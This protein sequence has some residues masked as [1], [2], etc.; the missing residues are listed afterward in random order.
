M[1]FH[2]ALTQPAKQAT[3]PLYIYFKISMR[4]KESRKLIFK[5][6]L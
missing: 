6:L 3:R 2:H 5:K 4:E 1:K